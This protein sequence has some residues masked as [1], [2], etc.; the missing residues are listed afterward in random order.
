MNKKGFVVALTTLA[1]LGSMSAFALDRNDFNDRDRARND[2]DR[3]DRRNEVVKKE[4]INRVFYGRTTLDL[5]QLLGIGPQFRGYEVESITL[6]AQALSDRRGRNDRDR[7]R[8]HWGDRAEATL[9]VDGRSVGRSQTIGSRMSEIV[10][11]PRSR[12]DEIGNEM[13]RMQIEIDGSVYIRSVEVV[14]K[15]EQQ[16]ARTRILE[17]DVTRIFVGSQ[18]LDLDDLFSGDRALRGARVLK[19]FMKAKT[20]FGMGTAQL[21]IDGRPVG[22]AERVDDRSETVDFVIRGDRIIGRDVSRV[23]IEL[24][25]AFLVTKVG[26]V[27]EQ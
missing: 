18:T 25:G 4:R 10:F 11:S 9:L 21:L 27:I 26:M 20:R 17:R 15:G 1:V 19:I 16:R 13:R 14:L 7:R 24:R 12:L 5:R 22:N 2:R 6:E 23:Q 3:G 8:D